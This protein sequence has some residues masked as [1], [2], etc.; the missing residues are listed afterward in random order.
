MGSLL[1]GCWLAIFATEPRALHACPVHD[2]SAPASHSSHHSMPMPGHRQCT[3][4]GDCCPA[5]GARIATPPT[6]APSRVVA[7][8]PI[9]AQTP[10]LVRSSGARVLLPPALGPPSIFG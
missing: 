8:V 1:L 4:P 7:F 5:A 9:D 2:I 6:F 10:V 3:C